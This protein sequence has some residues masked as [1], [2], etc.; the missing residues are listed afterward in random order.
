[1]LCVAVAAYH[2][3]YVRNI[4]LIDSNDVVFTCCTRVILDRIHDLVGG[5][6]LLFLLER[7]HSRQ[8]YHKH[9]FSSTPL[10]T[11]SGWLSSLCLLSLETFSAYYTLTRIVQQEK[12]ATCPESILK[13]GEL[14]VVYNCKFLL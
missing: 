11:P 4:L 14:K 13:L 8:T 6:S 3:M 1:M 10:A 7:E 9:R 5:A 12:T 2:V